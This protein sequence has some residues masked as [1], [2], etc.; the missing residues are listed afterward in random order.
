[1]SEVNSIVQTPDTGDLHFLLSIALELR[2]IK[3]CSSSSSRSGKFNEIESSNQLYREHREGII[4]L[5]PGQIFLEK[6][7]EGWLWLPDLRIEINLGLDLSPS[8]QSVR[9][10]EEKYR[11]S[12]SENWSLL[13]GCWRPPTASHLQMVTYKSQP[14]Q[15][16]RMP[17]P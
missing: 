12:C 11:R 2:E 14:V 4:H 17:I 15:L 7:E 6:E 9:V 8:T 5:N 1:M 10:R 16:H 3:S 13:D